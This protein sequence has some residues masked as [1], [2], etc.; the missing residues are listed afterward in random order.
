MLIESTNRVAQADSSGASPFRRILL[1]FVITNVIR[2]NEFPKRRSIAERQCC[3]RLGTDIHTIGHRRLHV[4]TGPQFRA[5]S[6][7]SLR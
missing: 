3:A 4:P 2:E 6:R 5:R 7:T 1:L